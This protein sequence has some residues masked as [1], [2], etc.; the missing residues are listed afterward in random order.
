MNVWPQPFMGLVSEHGV[1]T[2]MSRF[3]WPIKLGGPRF[4]GKPILIP[5]LQH[6]GMGWTWGRSAPPFLLLHATTSSILEGF[7]CFVLSVESC[8][9]FYKWK[10]FSVNSSY[11]QDLSMFSQRGCY[12]VEEIIICS[13]LNSTWKPNNTVISSTQ[14]H[15]FPSFLGGHIE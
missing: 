5:Y 14:N 10:C 15:R 1:F 8:F 4:A 11:C 2:N 12:L 13:S 7:Y 6:I 9:S 3:I